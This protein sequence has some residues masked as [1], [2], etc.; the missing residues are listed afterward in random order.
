MTTAAAPERSAL[1]KP[2][3]IVRWQAWGASMTFRRAIKMTMV[4]LVLAIAAFVIMIPLAW[5]LSTS[6]KN[7]KQIFTWPIEWMPK[8]IVWRNYPE[9][10]AA[11]PF[12]LWTR[13]TL[14]VA[15]LSVVGNCF[16]STMVGYS[17][18][19]LRWRAR[20]ALF[21]IMLATMMLPGQ[22]TM[23]PK[24]VIFSKIG[25]VNTFLPL[26]FP[27]FF[28]AGFNIFLMR[29][30]MMTL[31]LELDDAAKLDGCG[32]LAILTRVILPQSLP[33]LGF[34]AINTF[35]SRY[36]NFLRPLIYLN[37]PKLWTLPLGLR[38]YKDEFSVEWAY[39][40]AASVVAMLP[41]LVVFF[42]GQRYFIQGVV[43]TGVKG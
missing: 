14:L 8:P 40:M 16:S 7:S 3:L 27:T 1:T 22:V 28:G 17:F 37:R 4:Y 11:R 21:M 19:R 29:Q 36:N 35:K 10:L 18:S 23:I 6:L 34:V 15:V 41:L 30:F 38:T 31:P 24:F 13:N 5:M 12:W 25:W 26:F 42:F 33:A 39:L 9:A 20:D 2:R 43:F 32:Y